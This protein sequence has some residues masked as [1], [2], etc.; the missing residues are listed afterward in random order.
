MKALTVCQPWASL[1]A[2]GEKTIELR[3]RPTSHRGD[4]VICAGAKKPTHTPLRARVAT[5]RGLLG[6][7]RG[8][9]LCLVEIVGCR[10]AI[11]EDEAAACAPPAVGADYAW[12]MRVIRQLEPAP[13][14]GYLSFWTIADALVRFAPVKDYPIVQSGNG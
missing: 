12:T 6:A 3:S 8:V 10:L 5:D 9:T 4:L 2:R 7:P 13:V 14:S 1:I 11:A